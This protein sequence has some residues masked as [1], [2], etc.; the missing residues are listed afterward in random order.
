MGAQLVKPHELFKNSQ[1]EQNIDISS[2]SAWKLVSEALLNSFPY[3]SHEISE[4]ENNCVVKFDQDGTP[5]TLDKG[6]H[7]PPEIGI[8]FQG[9]SPDLINLAHEFS[10]AL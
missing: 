4:L 7:R 9:R 3:L 10:H 5:Y 2:Q 8:Y 1:A 6:R